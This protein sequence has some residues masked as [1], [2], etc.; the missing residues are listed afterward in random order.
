MWHVDVSENLAIERAK[1]LFDCKFANV[2][3]H[4]GAQANGAVLALETGDTTLAMSL[5]SGVTWTWC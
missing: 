1:K 2:Q 4:S 3:P 5:N